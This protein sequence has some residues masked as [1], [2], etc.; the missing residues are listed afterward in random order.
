MRIHAGIEQ[1]FEQL[2]PSKSLLHQVLY[3]DRFLN[4]SNVGY[5]SSQ[6]GRSVTNEQI[7]ITIND[8]MEQSLVTAANVEVQR[9]L[10]ICKQHGWEFRYIYRGDVDIVGGTGKE[11]STVK[12]HS[13]DSLEHLI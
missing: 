8:C 13:E 4:T 12:L 6:T 10:Y 7:M 2:Q 3:R 5:R 11:S 1:I 9:K